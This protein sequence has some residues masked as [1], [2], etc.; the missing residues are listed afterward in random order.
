[1]AG[2]ITELSNMGGGTV[3][4]TTDVIEIVDVSANTSNKVTPNNLLGITGTPVGTTDSQTLTNKTLT[5]PTISSPTLSGTLSGTYTIGGTPTFPASVVTLTGSQ[6]L[7]NKVLT[8]PTISAPTITNASITADAITGFTSANNGTIYGIAVT[9]STVQG[10]VIASNTVDA[11][12]IKWSAT[13]SNAGIWW[14]ELGRTTLGSAASSITLSGLAAR[15]NLHIL[16]TLIQSGGSI[17]TS[18]TLNNDTAANY[19]TRYSVNGAADATQVSQA[20]INF[21]LGASA[22]PEYFWAEVVNIAAQE[23]IGYVRSGGVSVAGAANAP[24][25][26]ELVF[27]W[28]N[29]ANQITRVDVATSTNNFAAGSAIIVLGHD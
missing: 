21:Q 2:K 5:S 12:R 25:K 16:F 6:T 17:T 20:N 9:S 28:A 19:A 18:F 14:E 1:M 26:E 22:A 29:T 27:K 10:T 24:Y 11:S 3:D 13:G 7:T 4:R 8:S 23:K 15:A